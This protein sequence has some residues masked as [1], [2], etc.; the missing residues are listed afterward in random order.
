MRDPDAFE[1]VRP[2]ALTREPHVPRDGEVGEQAVILR[3]VPDAAAL[4]TEVNPSLGIEP[5]LPP[6]RNPSSALAFETGDRS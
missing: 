3:E 1:Q 2:V 5:Q 6:E 4:G